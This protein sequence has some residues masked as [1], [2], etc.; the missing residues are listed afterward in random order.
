MWVA[1]SMDR[2]KCSRMER[3]KERNL[4]REKQDWKTQDTRLEKADRGDE[5]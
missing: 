4:P 1:R 2:P 5:C 3:R